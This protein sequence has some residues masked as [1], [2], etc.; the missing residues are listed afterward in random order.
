MEFVLLSQTDWRLREVERRMIDLVS[1]EALLAQH[2]E[3]RLQNSPQG[4]DRRHGLQ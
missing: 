1:G 2:K 4:F 3:A